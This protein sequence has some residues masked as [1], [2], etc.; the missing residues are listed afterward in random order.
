[1]TMASIHS[2][3]LFSTLCVQLATV[4]IIPLFLQFSVTF[5]FFI[6]PGDYIINIYMVFFTKLDISIIVLVIINAIRTDK[7]LGRI[8]QTP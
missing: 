6:I 8:T 7:F 5:V 2:P 4:L 1:M 3:L